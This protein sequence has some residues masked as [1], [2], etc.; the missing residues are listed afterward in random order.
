[1]CGI[2]GIVWLYANMSPEIT[3]KLAIEL[4]RGIEER[5]RDAA[6]IACYRSAGEVWIRKAPWPASR[7]VEY[8]ERVRGW[9]EAKII[10][11][12]ARAATSCTPGYNVCNHPLVTPAESRTKIVSLVHNGVIHDVEYLSLREIA[13]DTD[14][15]LV[16]VRERDR[17]DVEAV[18]EMSKI[19]GSKAVL[20][21]DGEKVYAFRD[22]SP[23]AWARVDKLIVFASTRNILKRALAAVGLSA[24]VEDFPTKKILEI[25]VEAGELKWHAK[26]AYAEYIVY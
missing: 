1:M 5:G 6:G 2:A 12:H 26:P 24:A 19:A 11:L 3:R 25:D 10:L 7:F 16:P 22:V 21:T 9:E 14:A 23:L 13:V 4:L 8:L 17:L 18:K 15:L 20:V